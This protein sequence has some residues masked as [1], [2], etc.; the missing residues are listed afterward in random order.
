M[1]AFSP[2]TFICYLLILVLF[3][4][5]GVSDSPSVSH[6]VFENRNWQ[7]RGTQSLDFAGFS[8]LFGDRVSFRPDSLLLQ[9][10]IGILFGKKTR[11]SRLF[12]LDSLSFLE[13]STNEMIL[14]SGRDTAVFFALDN[15]PSVGAQLRRIAERPFRLVDDSISFDFQILE[16]DDRFVMLEPSGDYPQN[17]AATNADNQMPTFHVEANEY[18]ANITYIAREMN[19]VSLVRYTLIG[20]DDENN[21]HFIRLPDY[22]PITVEPTVV[23]GQSLE[24]SSNLYLDS[25]AVV[26]LLQ[27]GRVAVDSDPVFS[28]SASVNYRDPAGYGPNHPL[29]GKEIPIVPYAD[30][31]LLEP[32]FNLDGTYAILNGNLPLESGSYTVS[33]RGGFLV[34]DSDKS[35]SPKFLPIH[36]RSP[37]SLA[38]QY[39]QEVKT[40]SEIGERF[41]STYVVYTTVEFSRPE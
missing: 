38:I 33:H 40:P 7:Y 18:T 34:L 20:L 24:G 17:R 35:N 5:C 22:S 26:Q 14:V 9:P 13:G 19:R 3:G 37:E 15:L 36:A 31:G 4:A 27:Y 1:L 2:S 28:G 8:L 39:A 23:S 12:S 16:Y 10:T 30:V 32:I 29:A 25:A 41:R 6:E 21:P 11:Q